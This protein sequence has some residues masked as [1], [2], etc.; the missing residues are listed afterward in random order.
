MDTLWIDL[1]TPSYPVLHPTSCRTARA[2]SFSDSVPWTEWRSSASCAQHVVLDRI[3]KFRTTDTTS[4]SVGYKTW[5]LS[6]GVSVDAQKLKQGTPST[7]F[8]CISAERTR[9]QHPW[10]WLRVCLNRKPSTSGWRWWSPCPRS[11]GTWWWSG[12]CVLTG[13]WETPRSVSSSPWPWLTLR[14]GLLSFR[15][16]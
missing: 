12:L 4:T 2:T 10:S 8:G 3:L 11:S 15:S 7:S 1:P 16:P 6:R 14:S 13:L 9:I 5:S